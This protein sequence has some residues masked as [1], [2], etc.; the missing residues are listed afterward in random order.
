MNKLLIIIAVGFLTACSPPSDA[1]VKAIAET[2]AKAG[3][4]ARL[5]GSNGS[6]YCVPVAK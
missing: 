5:D 4:T 3:M 6:V 2:C 1:V